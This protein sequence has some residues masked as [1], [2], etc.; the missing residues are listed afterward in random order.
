MFG[1][2][3]FCPSGTGRY[4][5][6]RK[7]IAIAFLMAAGAVLWS[8]HTRG[9]NI[10]VVDNNGRKGGGAGEYTTSGAVVNDGLFGDDVANP[11]APAKDSAKP[12][13]V[14]PFDETTAPT[15]KPNAD[16]ARAIAEIVKLAAAKTAAQKRTLAKTLLQKRESLTKSGDTNRY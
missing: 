6:F 8:A 4:A 11:D 3:R 15:P 5:S 12:A 13:A 1:L 9:D 10:F 2:K 14:N 7:V 16:E